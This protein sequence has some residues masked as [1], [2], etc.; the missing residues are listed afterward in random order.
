M[1]NELLLKKFP[2]R[3]VYLNFLCCSFLFLLCY[4]S[5]LLRLYSNCTPKQFFEIKKRTY[6]SQEYTAINIATSS[7]STCKNMVFL[8]NRYVVIRKVNPR[9]KPTRVRWIRLVQVFYLLCL[10][11]CCKA[12]TNLN[13]VWFQVNISIFQMD[14]PN[15]ITKLC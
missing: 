5:C 7:G 11:L 1:A 14:R 12:K 4:Q 13:L 8:R 6:R 15:L 3:T 10:V 2:F 9:T